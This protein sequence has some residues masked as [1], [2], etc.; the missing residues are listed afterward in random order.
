[1]P[2]KDADAEC[3]SELTSHGYTPCRCHERSMTNKWDLLNGA[4]KGIE[5][6]QQDDVVNVE[7]CYPRNDPPRVTT[8]QVSLMDVRAADSICIKY[9][10]KRDGWS[11]L[12]ASTFEWPIDDPKCDADWQ[13]VA[14]VQ[15]WA[16]EKKQ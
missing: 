13:E 16:R 15:A 1:M 12:Q 5:V 4:I 10:F 11:I 2:H 3:E 9:D 14:F 8:V 7:I 6:M